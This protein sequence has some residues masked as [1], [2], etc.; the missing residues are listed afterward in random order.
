DRAGRADRLAVERW[1]SGRRTAVLV[2][3]DGYVAWAAEDPDPAATEAAL[4][5]HVG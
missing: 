4:V 1:S 3:P 5:A 2:R